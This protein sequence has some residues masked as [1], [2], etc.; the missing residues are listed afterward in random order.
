MPAAP[1]VVAI[2]GKHPLSDADFAPLEIVRCEGCGH[3]YNAAY[4]PAFARMMY[5]DSFL[6]NMPVNVSMV[7]SLNSIVE[8]IGRDTFENKRV[9]EVGAGSGHLSRLVAK[10]A[11]HVTVYEPCKG[12]TSVELPEHNISLVND[13]FPGMRPCVDNCDLLICR[14]VIEHVAD[15]MTFVST[16]AAAIRYGGYAYFEVPNAAFLRDRV[17]ICEFHQA[18]VQYFTL[19]NF[20]NLVQKAG[21]HPV[22]HQIIKNGHDFGVLF[23]KG[24]DPGCYTIERASYNEHQ[25]EKGFKLALEE[26][27]EALAELPAPIAVYGATWQSQSFLSLMADG[28]RF[29]CIYDDNPHLQGVYLHG[30]GYKIP[31]LAPTEET[32]VNIETVLIG[33]YLHTQAIQDKLEKLGYSRII[34]SLG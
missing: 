10:N 20:I 8:W 31:V 6:T 1:L 13:M 19:T 12:L 33:A 32:L 17:V 2:E 15:P 3:V 16:M 14:Q 29:T 7:E 21:L 25:W 27:R 28:P 34:K 18:H 4:N 24:I 9:I 23:Q 11:K 22:R 30:A 26:W 5:A